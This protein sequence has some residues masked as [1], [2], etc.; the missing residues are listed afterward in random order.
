MDCNMLTK[1]YCE[2]SLYLYCEQNINRTIVFITRL[3]QQLW[4]VVKLIS[5]LAFIYRQFFQFYFVHGTH[6]SQ[7][8]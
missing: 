5:N 6:N 3:D 4:Q 7:R 1:Y 8:N 2:C